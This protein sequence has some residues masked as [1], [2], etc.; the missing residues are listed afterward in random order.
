[1]SNATDSTAFR[2][3]LDEAVKEA[4]GAV[5][6]IVAKFEKFLEVR[7]NE[8]TPEAPVVTAPEV[9][10][11]TVDQT[12]PNATASVVTAEPLPTNPTP[13]TPA[14]SPTLNNAN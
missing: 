7:V 2:L 8:L 3:E 6:T 1:M 11:A 4:H 10:V 14:T 5:D 12:L 9:P 13:P